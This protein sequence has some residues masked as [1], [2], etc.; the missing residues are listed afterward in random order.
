MAK[1]PADGKTTEGRTRS[2]IVSL[3]VP[4]ALIVFGILIQWPAV[5]EAFPGGDDS[6]YLFDGA[7]LVEQG[8]LMPLGSGPLAGISNA[9]VYLFFPRDH[10]YLGAVSAVRRAV[11]LAA[12]L[13]AVGLAAGAIGGRRAGWA[14]MLLAALAR[15]VSTVLVNSAD[16]LYTALGGLSFA[17][18]L[19]A[20]RKNEGGNHPPTLR[21]LAGAGLLLGFAAL[22]RLDGLLLGILLALAL[23]L[24][25][26]RNRTALRGALVFTGGFI[27]PL[28]AYVLIFGAATGRWDPELGQRSYLAFEQG[29][30]F[31]YTDRYET[32]PTP[33]SADL[34]GT[35]E[36]NGYSVP[37]AILRNPSAFLRRLPKV[38]VNA[39]RMFFDAYSILGGVMFLFLAA[40]GAAALWSSRK[41]TTLYLSLLWFVPLL[42]YMLASYR[43]GF[44]GTVFPELLLLALAGALPVL[45]QFRAPTGAEQIPLRA[46]WALV[47][48]GAILAQLQFQAGRIRALPEANRAAEE[49]R[50]W[51]GELAAQVPR[52]ECVIAYNTQDAIYSN[53]AVYGDWTIF[54]QK[55]TASQLA[56]TMRAGGC[57][58]LV[59]DSD[60]RSLTPDFAALAESALVPAYTSRDGSRE[61]FTLP[62]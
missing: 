37:R 44:F 1:T 27:L 36:Q 24:L 59:V 32:V 51:V 29:H 16:S 35:A 61:I 7:R 9:A 58:Y 41:R 19:W 60:M 39:A 11:L 50:A 45:A 6:G 4:L 49:Y 5:G 38:A 52:G 2:R 22:A 33:S 26:G 14:A 8:T 10:L 47:A 17:L 12:I 18:L 23:W 21:V 3:S 25:F 34:Y 42:G 46:V 40:A 31:L 28:L 13:A 43:P 55:L 15:P 20:A 62:G 53:H 57:R 48:A 30:N 56:E 54:S